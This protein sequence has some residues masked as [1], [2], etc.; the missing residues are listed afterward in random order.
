MGQG[1][2]KDEINSYLTTGQLVPAE[3][4]E[5]MIDQDLKNKSKDVLIIGYP[6]TSEQFLSFKLFGAKEKFSISAIWHLQINHFN[7]FIEKKLNEEGEK[8]WHEKFGDEMRETWTRNHDEFEMRIKGL[9]GLSDRAWTT[10][11][12]D[13]GEDSDID[14]IER[15]IKSSAQ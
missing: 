12:L 4:V 14:I 5:K 7:D 2:F 9:I 8:K 13:Y 10:I 11:K 6:L 1:R 15:K 3:T